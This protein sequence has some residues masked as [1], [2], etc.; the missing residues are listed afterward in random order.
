MAGRCRWWSRRGTSLGEHG[1]LE[2]REVPYGLHGPE[3][4]P[5]VAQ[6]RGVDGRL[7]RPCLDL[8]QDVE[9]VQPALVRPVPRRDRGHDG[10]AA[11]DLVASE[12][13]RHA[14]GMT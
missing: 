2:R 5:D 8:P 3:V 13:D 9:A 4:T 14:K 7:W 1:A 6:Q 12:V 10:A 11:A